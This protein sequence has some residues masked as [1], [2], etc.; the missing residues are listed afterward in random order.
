MITQSNPVIFI[1]LGQ[2][3]GI[4]QYLSPTFDK[5]I[6][7]AYF[8]V[9]CNYTD[10]WIRGEIGRIWKELLQQGNSDIVRVNYILGTDAAGLALPHLSKITEKYLSA[11]YPAGVLTDIYCLLDDDNLL[12]NMDE[13]VQII[14]MLKD[15]ANPHS[16]PLAVE[17]SCDKNIRMKKESSPFFTPH[18]RIYLLSNL[19]SQNMLISQES[20]AQTIAMLTMFKDCEPETYVTGADSSRYNELYFSDNCYGKHGVFFTAAS[21]NVAVPQDGLKALLI[22]ELLKIGK[23]TPLETGKDES[24]FSGF[25][26]LDAALD[27]SPPHKRMEYFLGMA[28]P[29]IDNNLSLTREEW[30]N[31]LFGESLCLN[32][33]AIP[34]A[35][36][37]EAQENVLELDAVSIARFKPINLYDLLRYTGDGGICEGLITKGIEHAKN[38]LHSLEEKFH[39][40]LSGKPNLT[41]GS[42]ESEKRRL[43]PFVTQQLWPYVIAHDYVYKQNHI[44]SFR[45][46]IV[47]LEKRLELLVAAHEEL[48]QHL[49]KVNDAIEI[50]TQQTQVIDNAFAPFSPS[51]S[52][53]FRALFKQFATQHHTELV[54]MSTEILPALI[55]DEFEKFL[56]KLGNYIDA[57]ILPSEFFNKP[58]I[59]T[60]HNLTNG[61]DISV[62][63]G[64]WVFNHR[65]WNIRLK[66]GYSHL[67]TE[68]NLF[69]P[70]Q[71]AA[72]VKRN[73]ESRGL[74]RMNLFADKNA[75]SVTIL[76]HAGTFNPEDLYYAGL[77]MGAKL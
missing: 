54:K 23:D 40:W 39:K 52:E 33:L 17:P 67:H 11:L 38:N 57:H 53:Y 75:D 10:R 5:H 18:L 15:I 63:L 74:G 30:I 48:Q 58:I 28:V 25:N 46:T 56:Q 73:Y 69:M 34:P 16:M 35:K 27:P 36:L 7:V 29:E 66:T 45:N 26:K 51:A 22:E 3:A 19:T 70:T 47:A 77:Y 37:S 31:H 62:A 59:D 68:I 55:R 2:G 4:W 50:Y 42:R 8:N 71:G 14:E 76:Y 60:M 41:K 61:T 1:T 21:L 6:H 20:I 12:E 72:D 13:R 32:D 9:P 65:Q 43:S 24:E 44:Q 49:S 64:D